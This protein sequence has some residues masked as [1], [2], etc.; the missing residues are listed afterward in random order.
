MHIDRQLSVAVPRKEH[1]MIDIVVFV[2]VGA[3]LAFVLP[4]FVPGRFRNRLVDIGI[5]SVGILIIIG[6]V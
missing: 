5:R 2:I 4:S 1:Q 3:V 6:A